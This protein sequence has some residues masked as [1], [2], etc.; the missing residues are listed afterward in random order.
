MLEYL[1]IDSGRAMEAGFAPSAGRLA[2][3]L[4]GISRLRLHR[5]WR[6]PLHRQRQSGC[7]RRR[8]QSVRMVRPYARPLGRHAAAVAGAVS[9][10][11]VFFHAS[12]KRA[13]LSSACSSSSRTGSTPRPTW[14]MRARR[15][16]RWSR[17]A[18]R[19]LWSTIST[20]SF[21]SLGVLNYDTKIA[22][23]VRT[24]GLVRNA[25]VRRMAGFEIALRGI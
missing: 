2:G 1:A 6:I 18:I 5:A 25:G 3:L 17:P 23:V 9:A 16:C 10:G 20:Q 11:G 12:A 24:A 15:N 14:P 7:S 21:P 4:C 19:I 22:T 8:T 13:G